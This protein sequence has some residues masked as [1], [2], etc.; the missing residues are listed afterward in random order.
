MAKSF[1]TDDEE[2]QEWLTS[3][4][5]LTYKPVIFAANVTEDDLA[6]D[7]ADNAGVQKCGNTQQKRTVKYL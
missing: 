5:L 4:N 2:E 6:N 7:G 3:Y 1:T